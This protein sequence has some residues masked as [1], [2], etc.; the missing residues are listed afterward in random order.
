M[1]HWHPHKGGWWMGLKGLIKHLHGQLV[2]REEQH[3][4]KDAS[5]FARQILSS[6]FLSKGWKKKVFTGNNRAL[7][8]K[9]LMKNSMLSC[10]CLIIWCLCYAAHA[11]L[12]KERKK[13]N[14][15][16][17]PVASVFAVRWTEQCCSTSGF[18]S[19]GAE[20]FI[21]H[22]LHAWIM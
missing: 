21:I 19:T 7:E 16:G 18:T 3:R 15:G 2:R 17:Q 8:N 9:T 4:L 22:K 10:W 6:W 14:R 11:C 12:T 20:T 13:E 5:V 1:P